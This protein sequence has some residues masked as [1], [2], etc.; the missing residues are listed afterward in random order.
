[1]IETKRP[2]R[3]VLIDDHRPVHLAVATILQTVDDIE[4]AGQGGNGQE[5][6]SLCEELQPDLILLDVIMPLMDGIEAAGIIHQRF[7]STKILVLSSYQDQE[8]VHA[9]LKNGAVGYITKGA[10][11]DGLIDTIRTAHQGKVVFSPEAAAAIM[12][13]GQPRKVERFHLT[14]RELE[15]LVLMADGQTMGQIAGNLFISQST[16]KFHIVNI[17]SKLGVETRSEGLIVAA[18]NNL[19]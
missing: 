17:L 1:M 2:I 18:K 6:V 19:I 9:M 13:D 10:L 16:V 14:D 11:V 7:P 15:V 4:L 8:S 3:V 12:T 5:A